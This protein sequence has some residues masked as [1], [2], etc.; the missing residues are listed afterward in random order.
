MVRAE[1]MHTV[2]DQAA[3]MNRNSGSSDP[4]IL[5]TPFLIQFK[6]QAPGASSTDRNVQIV[7]LNLIV[8]KT[9][10]HQLAIRSSSEHRAGHGYSINERV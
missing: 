10:N 4:L 2:Y 7:D 6:V 5:N 1:G 3:T 8:W 9:T